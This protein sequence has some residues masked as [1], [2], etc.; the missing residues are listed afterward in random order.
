MITGQ[1]EPHGGRNSVLE[2]ATRKR[3]VSIHVLRFERSRRLRF[4]STGLAEG[5]E[6]GLSP[7]TKIVRQVAR[8]E[9]ARPLA[10][11]NGDW[12]AISPG[13]Y[14]GDPRGLQVTAGELVSAPTG[15]NS[16]WV[17]ADGLPHLGVLGNQ[18]EFVAVDCP[19]TGENINRHVVWRSSFTRPTLRLQGSDGFGWWGSST[20]WAGSRIL[21]SPSDGEQRG[22]A[23]A[24]I[25]LEKEHRGD[26]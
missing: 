21:N 20:L 6:Y 16:F 8:R 22:M 3:P 9:R 12:F 4:W 26:E 19:G 5:R 10:A 23:N 15:H 13:N 2:R 25:L 18:D 17:D 7:L 1:I 11:I 24:L 14:Q